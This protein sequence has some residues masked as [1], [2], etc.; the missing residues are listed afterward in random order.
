MGSLARSKSN[1]TAARFGTNAT[2]AIT[3]GSSPIEN[4]YGPGTA[5]PSA[6]RS[7]AA[8]EKEA[9]YAGVCGQLRSQSARATV[10]ALVEHTGA[11]ITGAARA[12]LSVGGASQGRC[13]DGPSAPPPVSD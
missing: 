11:R 12:S 3:S 13:E 9:A 4:Q 7:V 5:F 8:L 1:R 6:A 10:R 2:R